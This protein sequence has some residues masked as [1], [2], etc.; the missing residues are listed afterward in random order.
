LEVVVGNSVLLQEL[1]NFRKRQLLE[2]LRRRLPN[3][4]LNDLKFRAGVV[5][6]PP[7]P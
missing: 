2:Q 1:A 3:T 4:P 6:E 7:K 5:P